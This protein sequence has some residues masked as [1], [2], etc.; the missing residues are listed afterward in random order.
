VLVMSILV[1]GGCAQD[2]DEIRVELAAQR[3]KV[4]SAASTH[5]RETVRLAEMQDSLQTKVQH[6]VTAL[7]LSREQAEALEQ[8]H[9]QAQEALVKAESRNLERQRE[10]LA[11][12]QKALYGAPAP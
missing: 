1:F 3:A 2:V 9:L 8:A 11:A 12:L 6:G 5:L 10:Y 7:G 4:D